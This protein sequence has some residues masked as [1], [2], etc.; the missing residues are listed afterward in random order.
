MTIAPDTEWRTARRADKAADREQD[1]L[2]AE[3]RARQEREDRL[4]RDERAAARRAQED[5]RK[6]QDAAQRRKDRAAA[7]TAR[8][9]R[10]RKRAATVREHGDV[11]ATLAVMACGMVPALVAQYRA[12]VALGM[13]LLLGCLLPLMLELGAW[14]ATAGEAKALKEGRKVW[15]YRTAVWA[16]ASLAAGVNAWHG[17]HDYGPG[18]GVIL[19]ASSIAPVALWHMVM[20]GRHSAKAKR[21]KAEIAAERKARAQEKQRT[22]HTKSR[23]KHHP[24]VAEVA[25]RLLSAAAFG[26]LT[27]E[28]AWAQ[29][30]EAVHGA[31]TPGMTAELYAASAGARHRLSAAFELAPEQGEEIR[32]TLLESFYG[33]SRQPLPVLGK[34]SSLPRRTGKNSQVADQIP[35][36]DGKSEKA[37]KKGRPMPPRRRKG[38]TPAYHPAARTAARETALRATS[39]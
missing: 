10:W 35:P 18:G 3:L 39:A 13:G 29:A 28:E 32:T 1:R 12:L 24:K 7:A 20:A 16:F 6:R 4:F 38:D 2:D 36:A 8:T 34:F 17:S 9:A 33:P 19:A 21:T 27:P 14:A 15:P 37:S 5:E 23:R 31:S 11:A 25:D 30:W 26:T 22:A